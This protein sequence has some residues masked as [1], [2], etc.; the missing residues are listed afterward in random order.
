MNYTQTLDNL[1]IAARQMIETAQEILDS[2]EI[3]RAAIRYCT[4]EEVY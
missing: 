4:E 3:E 2:V 1:E